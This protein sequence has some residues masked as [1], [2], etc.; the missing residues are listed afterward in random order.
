MRERTHVLSSGTELSGSNSAVECQLPKL[1]VV[2]SSP[3]SRSIFNNLRTMADV[4]F[5][6]LTAQF[7]L[8]AA[9][10]PDVET[11]DA[12]K[13]SVL[14]RCAGPVPELTRSESG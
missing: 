10:A 1:D 14:R 7:A 11:F 5:G 6:V 3:I 13:C 9:E 12:V 8:G 4:L 2:G